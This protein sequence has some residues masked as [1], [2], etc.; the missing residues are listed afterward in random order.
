MKIQRKIHEMEQSE[1]Q[2][3]DELSGSLEKDDGGWY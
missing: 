2:I 3:S 1:K